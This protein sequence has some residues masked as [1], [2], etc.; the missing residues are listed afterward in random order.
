MAAQERLATSAAVRREGDQRQVLDKTFS[1]SEGT[2]Q[3]ID[4]RLPHA[5]RS[6]PTRWTSRANPERLAIQALAEDTPHSPPRQIR[7][8]ER[9]IA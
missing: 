9:S 4:D 5:L 7:A 2:S 1:K 8:D 6:H 3:Y